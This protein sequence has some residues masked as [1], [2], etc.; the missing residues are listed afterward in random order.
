M[1]AELNGA[2][3]LQE[4]PEIISDSQCCY[5]SKP[6]K[7]SSGKLFELTKPFWKEILNFQNFFFS[8]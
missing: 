3:H 8:E 4:F 1:Y 6:R 2:F 7:L 5:E